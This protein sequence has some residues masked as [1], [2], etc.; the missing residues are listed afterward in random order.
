MRVAS[1]PPDEQRGPLSELLRLQSEFQARLA[2]ETLR[3]LRRLQGAFAP[4]APGTV[5]RPDGDGELRAAGRPGPARDP[6]ARGRESPARPL[7]GDAHA[8]A[9]RAHAP[10]RRGS[11][12]PI[13]RPPPRCWRPARS[14]RWRSSSSCR[15]SCP[16]DVYKG[17]LVLQGFREGGVPVTIDA[18]DGAPAPSDARPP[19]G[20]RPPGRGR[21]RRR[22]ESGRRDEPGTAGRRRERPGTHDGHAGGVARGAAGHAALRLGRRGGGL[23]GRGICRARTRAATDRSR[24]RACTGRSSPR[25]PARTARRCGRRSRSA[26][27]RRA[28]RRARSWTISATTW[29]S[30]WRTTSRTRSGCSHPGRGGGQS[31]LRPTTASR[32]RSPTACWACGCSRA[33][34]PVRSMRSSAPPGGG[35]R[36][37]AGPDFE[38][39]SA[40]CSA[41]H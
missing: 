27:G 9:A 8:D 22:G 31:R 30:S 34:S 14:A 17:A 2:D 33:R 3:Y 4:A 36:G 29:R 5:V 18:S 38:R 16:P 21:G 26:T 20:R 35:R 24:G 6:P 1:D 32:R 7:P 37:R 12:R 23:A 11:R 19:R 41:E 25:A 10:G 13:R 28:C 15:R 39:P 40:R